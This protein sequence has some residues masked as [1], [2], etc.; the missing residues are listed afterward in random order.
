MSKP[1]KPKQS[2]TDKTSVGISV[3]NKE[4]FR[5]NYL[6]KLKEKVSTA[7]QEED[8]M[9]DTAEGRA[10]ADVYQSL[11]VLPMIEPTRNLNLYADLSSAAVDNVAQGTYQALVGSRGDQVGGIKSVKGIENRTGAAM[12]QLAKIETAESLQKLK[13]ESSRA[14]GILKGG[15]TLGKAGAELYRTNQLF[16]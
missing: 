5:N 8:S 6:P 12:S 14:S 16:G 7:F 2:E 3:A 15:A 11:G 10:N 4:F 9:M 13:N 1:D